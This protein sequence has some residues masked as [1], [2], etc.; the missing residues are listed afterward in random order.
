[1]TDVDARRAIDLV[2]E[3]I[4]KR[5]IADPPASIVER[6]GQ[7]PT[8]EDVRRPVW[9]QA[10]RAL[11]IY[12]TRYG[13]TQP[14]TDTSAR[15]ANEHAKLNRLIQRAEVSQQPTN[16][17]KQ[18]ASEL[19]TARRQLPI[20]DAT[21][22][23]LQTELTPLVTAAAA[24][25]AV[26]VIELLGQRPE[27]TDVGRRSTWD[28]AATHIEQ[29]RHEHGITLTNTTS[30]E[31]ETTLDR[32]VGIKPTDD[33]DHM[34]FEVVESAIRQVVDDQERVIARGLRR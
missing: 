23:R 20:D 3:R 1:L 32:A 27:S 30:D 22:Q 6:F 2:G 13:T 24:N 5:A 21:I 19:A 25:P 29:W 9:D 26:Y 28:R 4:A 7:R 11:T 16:D 12:Q 8:I 34:R 10:V 31:Q 14:P 15:Q 17:T 18:I 33:V